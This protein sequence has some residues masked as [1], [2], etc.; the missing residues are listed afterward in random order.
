[1]NAIHPD[2]ALGERWHKA[3]RRP[4]AAVPGLVT[5]I[6]LA[7][8]GALVGCSRFT[9]STS[10]SPPVAT[11]VGAVIAWPVRYPGVVYARLADGFGV[12]VMTVD[13]VRRRFAEAR[14][15][16]LVDR[17]RPGRPKADLSL[18]ETE[19]CQMR[20]WSGGRHQPKR[21]RCVPRSCWL[22]LAGCPPKTWPRR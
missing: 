15:A 5:G 20:G 17:A 10:S 1:M 6:S 21:C 14:L 8:M 2:H 4:G 19:R 22:A 7:A 3:R 13:K 16:G 9:P 12:S 18:T 11:V